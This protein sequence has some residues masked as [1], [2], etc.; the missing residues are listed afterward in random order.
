[1]ALKLGPRKEEPASRS[2][3]LEPPATRRGR[4]CSGERG[5]PLGGGGVPLGK[6]WKISLEGGR[7]VTGTSAAPRGPKVLAE[8]ISGRAL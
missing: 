8:V 1:M 2:D 4:C 5:L 7:A 6:H 3:V